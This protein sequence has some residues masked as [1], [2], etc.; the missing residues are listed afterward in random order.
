MRRGSHLVDLRTMRNF[1]Q[2]DYF[3]TVLT[4]RGKLRPLT[5]MARKA[6]F[7]G[8]KMVTTL[9]HKSTKGGKRLKVSYYIVY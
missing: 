1:A 8:G 9:V 3:I 5:R 7:K 2:V 4:S 6:C